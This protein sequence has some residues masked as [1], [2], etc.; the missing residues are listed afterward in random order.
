MLAVPQSTD[1]GDYFPDNYDPEAEIAFS[2]GMMGSQEMLTGGDRGGP[3]LPGLE[4]VGADAVIT[5]GIEMS[6]EI[7]PGMDFTPNPFYNG[8]YD[9]QA[10]SS[11]QGTSNQKISMIKS[12][13][14]VDSVLWLSQHLPET[15]IN[16]AGRFFDNPRQPS[17][18][19]I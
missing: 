14:I 10:P 12:M 19:D 2:S 15:C 13:L 9:F 11:G 3:Q 17:H 18:H 16:T 1:T 7:P 5:G 8:E 6:S 4:N